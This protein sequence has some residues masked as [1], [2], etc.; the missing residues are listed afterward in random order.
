M[1][2]PATFKQQEET[3]QPLYHVR[4][5]SEGIRSHPNSTEEREVHQW[6]S[7]LMAASDV[8]FPVVVKPVGCAGSFSV[9][10]AEDTAQ[11][12]AALREFNSTLP[13]YL[14]NSGLSSD[15]TAAT[16]MLISAFCLYDLCSKLR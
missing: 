10:K 9:T 2:F 15:S 6:L 5:A 4:S 1:K 13:T 8:S 7:G 3:P 12:A 14:A 11:L 16:G